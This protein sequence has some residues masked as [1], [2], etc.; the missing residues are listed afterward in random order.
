VAGR[1]YGRG[2]TLPTLMPLLQ[3]SAEYLAARGIANGKR[4]AEWIF[5][6]ALA[7]TRLELYTRFDMPLGEP[8]VGRLRALVQRRGKREP[9]AYVLGTQPFHGLTLRVG[10]GVLVPRPETEELV[11][12]VLAELP[13]G[14]ARVVDVGTGSGAIALAIKAARPEARVEGVD[15]SAEALAYATANGERLGHPV[16]WRA[17]DLLTGSTVRYDAVVA[18]L[19]YIAEDERGECDPELAFEPPGALFAGEAGLA[20]IARLIA[21]AQRVLAPDG[22]LWLEHGWRQGDGVR[23]LAARHGLACDIVADGSGRDRMARLR[24]G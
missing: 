6:E 4:E 7:L 18:N 16:E 24:H 3:K 13:S 10:P 8:E 1:V 21:D 9:L 23:A 20:L 11:D 2:M 14:P 12:R 19:P 17:G 22:R 5:A 15:A